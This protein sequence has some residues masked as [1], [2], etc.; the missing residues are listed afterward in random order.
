L[1][2]ACGQLSVP[3]VPRFD[4]LEE[5][6]GAHWHSARWNHDVPLADA[7]IGLIGSGASA[8]QI[9]P[10][11]AV[12]TGGLSV[13]Q[14]TPPWIIPRKDRPYTLPERWAFERLPAWRRF[15]RGYIYWRLESFYLGFGPSDA[16]HRMLENMATKHREKHVADPELR[17]R[18]TP[19]Y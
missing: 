8:I 18:L 12:A 2:A 1:V 6:R 13:F 5:F 17:R 15:Y 19:G 14:R 3:T 10:R 16:F 9:V 11:L 4:G 7:R